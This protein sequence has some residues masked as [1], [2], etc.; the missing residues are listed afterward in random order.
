MSWWVGLDRTAMREAQE[1]EQP[2]MKAAKD[3]MP[4]AKETGSAM[5]AYHRASEKRR[6]KERES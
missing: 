3:L 6:R 4:T 1:R 2:R 5:E